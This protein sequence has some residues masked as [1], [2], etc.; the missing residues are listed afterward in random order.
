MTGL[1]PGSSGRVR[2][3]ALTFTFLFSLVVCASAAAQS[4]TGRVTDPAGQP[5]SGAD[6]LILRDKAVVA[7]TTS[8]ADGRFEI[9]AL[10]PGEYEVTAA[11]PGL[12]APY[13]PISVTAAS[14]ADISVPLAVSPIRESVVVSASHVDTPL[15]RTAE[16]VTLFDREELE[17]LQIA[18]AADALR[19]VPGFAIAASGGPGAL[20]SIFPRGGESDY[21]LV[22]VDGIPQNAFG[23]GFDAAHLDT[24]GLERVEVV[25]GPN[26]ALYGNGAIG[27]VVHLVTRQGGPLRAQVSFEGGGYGTTRTTGS[28]SGSRGAW[29][30]GGAFDRFTSDGDTRLRPTIGRRVENDDYD[31]LMGSGS[32]GWSDRPTRSIRI[33][34]R[35]ERDVR[36]FPGPHGSDPMGLYAGLDRISR[37]RT[38]ASGLG[39]SANFGDAYRGRHGL[40]FTWSDAQA[41][42]VSPPFGCSPSDCA[43]DPLV[44]DDRTRRVTGR[45]QLDFERPRMG[46]SAGWEVVRER[47]DNTYITG[48]IFE[49]V[50]IRRLDSG[51][52]VEGRPSLG[53][54]L[55]LTAGVRLERIARAALEPSPGAR[56]AFADQ[57]VWS[58]NP[59]VSAAWFVRGVDATNWTKLRASAGTGIKPPTGFDIAFTNNPDLKPERSRSLEIGVE[60]A[61][62]RAGL[63]ADAAWFQNRYDDLIVTAGLALI[64]A[65]R[66]R[67]DNIANARAHGLELGLRW[68]SRTGFGARAAWTWMNTKV[69]AVDGLSVAQFPYGV[70]DAL[71]RRARH[72]GVG[73]I[74]WTRDRVDA[75]LTLGGRGS[76]TDLEPNFI[77]DL[78]A[79]PG[80]VNVS[81]GGALTLAR[82]VE[83]FGRVTNALDRRYEE[84]FGYPALGRRAS[85]GVRIAAGR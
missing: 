28:A 42:Y 53:R 62:A 20:T 70:G 52:F 6:V 56:P 31:R 38:T 30:W 39:A 76:M 77:S 71:P 7:T 5:V 85:V 79:N 26:S 65:S 10:A 40:Q 32:L 18:T 16:S 54:D 1:H 14:N 37:G 81:L 67:T 57:I 83:V 61:L 55:L 35:G 34:V 45:Y 68:R 33:D 23:G 74:T 69:L 8:G 63:V 24:A 15:S 3:L 29:R 73:E 50:P 72:H 9:P 27:G 48:E 2:F 75:F 22:L 46:L 78:V 58:L 49:P 19:L 17:T 51:L 66:Y 41:E 13:Q 84:V 12:S 4:L 82:N 43:L 36:G 59:K 47:V 44:A 80:Y 11:A 64:G 21:T 25:R 60:Q